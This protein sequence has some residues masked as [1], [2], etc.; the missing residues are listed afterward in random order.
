VCG[1]FL[2]RLRKAPELAGFVRG[3]DTADHR[4]AMVGGS[5]PF[6]PERAK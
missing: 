1:D 2:W 6:K 3:V 4:R 5:K